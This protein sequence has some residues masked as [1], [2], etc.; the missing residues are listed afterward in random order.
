MIVD[1]DSESGVLGTLLFQALRLYSV[2]ALHAIVFDE[3]PL[4]RTAVARE[5]QVRG[6]VSTYELMSRSSFDIREYV[7]EISAFTLGQLGTP[8]RPF[9]EQSIPLLVALATDDC[10]D[11]RAAAVSS[12]GHSRANEAVDAIVKAGGDLSPEV[13]ASAATALGRVSR[14]NEVITALQNLYHDAEQDVREWAGLSLELQGVALD[15]E[16]DSNRR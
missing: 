7:R 2:E 16:I 4:V 10:V 9:R 13:R 15:D 6:D 12:L 11:V 14:S 3:N 5:L 1:D 8:E